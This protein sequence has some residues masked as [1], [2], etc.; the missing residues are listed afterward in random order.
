MAKQDYDPSSD[1]ASFSNLHSRL[2]AL[3][4][5]AVAVARSHPDP[6]KL[7]QSFEVTLA[8]DREDDID[9]VELTLEM[10]KGREMRDAFTDSLVRVIK[11]RLT[12][13]DHPAP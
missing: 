13:N 10:Q 5:F 12:L 8:E 7:L 6:S 1:A 3:E 9:V 2:E 11:A 4:S